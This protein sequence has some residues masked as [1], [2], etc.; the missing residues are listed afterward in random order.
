MTLPLR[1]RAWLRWF[2]ANRFGPLYLSLVLFIA[3][4]A[5]TRLVLAALHLDDIGSDWPYLF[6]AMGIGLVFDALTA[7]VLGTPFAL[8]LLLTSHRRLAKRSTKIL[9]GA[10]FFIHLFALFYLCIA[11]VVF[12]QE[13]TARFNYVAVDYLI[14]PKEVFINIRDTY[15]VWWALA[16]DLVCSAALFLV[17]R[18]PLWRALEKPAAWRWRIRIGAVYFA[19]LLLGAVG[20]NIN[21]GQVS[22]NRVVNELA[23]NGVYSF[24]H[25]L[26]TNEVKYD[27]L[28]AHTDNVKALTRARELIL[29]DNARFLRPEDP[30]SLDRVITASGPARRMNVVLVLEESLGSKFVGSLHPEGPSVMPEFDQ[31]ARDGLFFTHIYATGNRTVRGIEATHTGLPPMPGRSVVK[32]NGGV[33]LFTLPSVLQQKG[34][35]T[36]FIYGGRSY[37]DNIRDFALNNGFE[38][39]VD[40][41]DFKKITFTTIWGVC[42]EDIFDN[43]LE[44]FDAMHAAGKPF[45]TTVLTVSNHPPF[46]YPEGRIVENPDFLRKRENAMRYAD[47][48][49]GKFMRDA[50]SH[51]FF[52]NTLFVFLGDHGARVYGRQEIPL[53]SYEVPVLFYSP[54][55]FAHGRRMDMLG[56]QMDVAP[57]I[58]GMLNMNY[59][60]RFFGRDLLRI[61]P[62]KR[63]ALMTHNRDI[64]LLHDE[65]LAVLGVRGARELWQRDP[66]TGDLERLPVETDPQLLDDAVAYFQSAARLYESHRLS[67][68]TQTP[69]PQT[70]AHVRP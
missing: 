54:K 12:F 49:L 50:R 36:A 17:L 58:L 64:A 65:R 44:E 6:A 1:G 5:L 45:F 68:L 34:Y 59:N 4:C 70:S 37:F 46:T 38:R 18:G 24:L 40:Q 60:S 11:E 33:G 14:Y 26:V 69:A 3:G 41:D 57:T 42:D 2:E 7:L 19:V 43:A 47:Y 25:A 20:L 55:L 23:G 61:P 53:E 30:Y 8:F 66:K 9:V 39:V 27:T 63:W 67:T 28:Y 13:F 10:I 15:P 21:L 56:S 16:A 29:T 51:A 35:Q 31:L 48:A 22:D 62:D 32:R 52:D